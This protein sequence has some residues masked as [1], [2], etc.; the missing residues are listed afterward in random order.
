MSGL[1]WDSLSFDYG[2]KVISFPYRPQVV[3]VVHPGRSALY[4]ETCCTMQEYCAFSSWKLIRAM[5]RLNPRLHACQASATLS[6]IPTLHSVLLLHSI[7]L[8]F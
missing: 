4:G 7:P 1:L 6:Q 8:R 2:L 5:L 3:I